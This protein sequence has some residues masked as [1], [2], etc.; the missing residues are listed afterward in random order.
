MCIIAVIIYLIYFPENRSFAF[1][2]KA[3]ISAMEDNYFP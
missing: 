2:E 3:K 1:Y